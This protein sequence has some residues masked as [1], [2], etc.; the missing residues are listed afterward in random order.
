[1]TFCDR[2]KKVSPGQRASAL[3]TWLTSRRQTV[4]LPSY[5]PTSTQVSVCVE[6][7]LYS[8]SPPPLFPLLA[9]GRADDDTSQRER[10]SLL[11]FSLLSHRRA[12]GR[13]SERVREPPTPPQPPLNSQV[14]RT[15]DFRPSIHPSTTNHLTYRLPRPHLRRHPCKEGREKS[16]AIKHG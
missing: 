5:L 1:M 2:K 12:S 13:G 10:A 7:K 8:P 16:G 9:H 6:S 11:V 4:S 14:Q 15:C 3:P